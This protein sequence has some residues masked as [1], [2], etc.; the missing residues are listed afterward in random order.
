MM[1]LRLQCMSYLLTLPVLAVDFQT[2]KDGVEDDIS[3]GNAE[4]HNDGRRWLSPAEIGQHSVGIISSGDKEPLEVRDDSSPTNAELLKAG[5]DPLLTDLELPS[6][7]GDLLYGEPELSLSAENPHSIGEE[8]T[9]DA[10]LNTIPL[11]KY[12]T[13]TTAIASNNKSNDKEHKRDKNAEISD[14]TQVSVKQITAIPPQVYSSSTVLSSESNKLVTRPRRAGNSR[15]NTTGPDFDVSGLCKSLYKSSHGL[16]RTPL[17]YVYKINSRRFIYLYVMEKIVDI[18]LPLYRSFYKCK[19]YKYLTLC[20]EQKVGFIHSHGCKRI[21]EEDIFFEFFLGLYIISNDTECMERVCD[22]SFRFREASVKGVTYQ[23]F[24][25]RDFRGGSK[26]CHKNFELLGTYASGRYNITYLTVNNLWPICCPMCVVV[27]NDKPEDYGIN[28]GWSYLNDSC[29]ASEVLLITLVA[30]VAV[31]GVVGN[32]LVLV[33]M[34]TSRHGGEES[35]MLRTSLALADL[36]TVLFVVIPALFYHIS[37]FI[38]QTHYTVLNKRAYF[39]YKSV[40]K[41]DATEL[42]A[43]NFLVYSKGYVLFQSLL[44]KTCSTVSLFIMFLLSVERLVLTGRA[45]RYYDY[46]SRGRIKLV[47]VSTWAVSLM[48]AL[49]NSYDEH[50]FIIALWSTFSKLPTRYIRNYPD[51]L[52]FAFLSNLHIVLHMITVLATVILSMLAFRNFL[53][54]REREHSEWNYGI[55]STRLYSK[56]DRR[57]LI[58]MS[59][60]TAFYLIS[61]VPSA[62]QFLLY[63]TGNTPIEEFLLDYFASWI[64]LVNTAWNP[65]VY[66]FCSSQFISDMAEMLHRVLPERLGCN[67]KP[68]MIQSQHEY[69]EDNFELNPRAKVML[70]RLGFPETCA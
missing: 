18:C 31:S 58:T 38:K 67:L 52:L 70:R 69:R 37:P 16:P 63:S 40:T 12:N 41:R 21:S 47:I 30:C 53:R 65:W 11:S 10:S 61:V 29:R 64:F 35:S 5:D 62:I 44:S 34:L 33:V 26:V 4:S 43:K 28:G 17:G 48:I 51:V 32:V 36:L 2:E 54:E 25:L 66:N 50:G 22:G 42:I 60:I 56:D 23:I 46:I 68:H 49:L 39:N 55:K 15:F 13:A 8:S 57:I 1:W 9:G 19:E 24:N 20:I 59:F 45:L 3:H 6:F 27:W 14:K 7:G